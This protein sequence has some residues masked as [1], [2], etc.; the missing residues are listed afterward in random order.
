VRLSDE[1]TPAVAGLAHGKLCD[2]RAFISHFMIYARAVYVI[3]HRFSVFISVFR[4]NKKRYALHP[5]GRTLDP[6]E[7]QVDNVVGPVMLSG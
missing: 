4:H 3:E 5:R 2:R 7:H 6:C 1:I